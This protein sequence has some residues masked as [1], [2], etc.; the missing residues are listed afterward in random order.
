LLDTA[1]RYCPAQAKLIFLD[2]PRIEV[3]DKAAAFQGDSTYV[4]S[5][6]L[7]M[8]RALI[9]KSLPLL[10]RDGFLVIQAGDTEEPF[11]RLLLEELLGRENYVGTIVWQRAYGPRNM[12]GM[13]EFT[14]THDC[15]LLF[16]N[17]KSALPFVG[18][19]LSG[20]AAGFANPDEDPRG[21]WRAA[22]KGARTRRERSDFN[23]YVPPYRWEV[24]AGSLPPGI[25]RLNLFTG[26]IW[27]I[28]E[29]TG[30]FDF[31]IQVSDSSGRTAKKQFE[32]TCV[33]S[34]ECTYPKQI[35]W[36]FAEIA[37]SGKLRITT[38]D[39]GIAVVG[40]EYRELL[41]AEGGAPFRSTPKRP[42][43]GRY[44]EFADETLVDAYLTDKVDLGRDGDVIPRI[45]NYVHSDD[46]V[47]I[48]QQT[49]WPAQ[50]KEGR[51]FAGYTQ[52]ATKHLKGLKEKNL[53]DMSV[54]TSKPEH[55][56]ARLLSI[57]THPDDLVVDVYS[58]SGDLAATSS[59]LGRR[60]LSLSGQ[61]QRDEE[62]LSRC[63]IPRLQAVTE[64]RDPGLDGKD[65]LHDKIELATTKK[66]FV[67]YE[68]GDWIVERG[69]RDEYARLN[70]KLKKKDELFATLLTAFGYWPVSRAEGRSF[71]GGRAIVVD[72]ETELTPE[73]VLEISGPE[74]SDLTIF[75][76]SAS[77][78]FRAALAP[79]GVSYRRV[80]SGL[81]W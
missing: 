10:R 59:K 21:S 8:L 19:E 27:G 70:P 66:S 5:T 11:M 67:V 52:D 23:T 13:K 68:L 7:T 81:S 28:P 30:L 49:W 64:G 45:K 24:V 71:A 16:A 80:P 78:D 25:W 26:V 1:S 72:P 14:A 12:R 40:K 79:A 54:T 47:V 51:I 41:L 36:L 58:I 60:W 18:L 50:D 46:T 34:A 6:W 55:L 53:I 65:E 63:I 62:L 17:D 69:E 76:F 77:D 48:N 2:V 20:L 38:K 44:W 3:D 37:S 61:S 31:E 75:Y 33:E 15:I 9:S 73:M 74:A 56:L 22:H 32:I 39:L 57:L 43:E 29:E 4:Y 35:P 42:G